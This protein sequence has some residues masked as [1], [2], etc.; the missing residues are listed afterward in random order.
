MAP[1]DGYTLSSPRTAWSAR[2]R[3]SPSRAYDLFKDIKPLAELSRSG[4]VLVGNAALP[5]SNLKELIAY[6]KAN[7]GKVSYAS[8]S[9][10]TM[11]HIMGVEL[12]KLA[13]LDMTHVG[14]KGSPPALQDVMGGHVALMFDGLATSIPMLKTGKIKAY[15]VSVAQAHERAARCADLH[16]TG[17]PADRRFAWIGLWTASDVPADVQPRCAKRR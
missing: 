5:A 12:T 8:Y 17:L 4:L 13:G 14:Y 3:T 11:S 15:A 7:P 1:H 16:R 10:G 2:F 6:V 9:T